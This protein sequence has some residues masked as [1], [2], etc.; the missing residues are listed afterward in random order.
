VYSSLQKTL[1]KVRRKGVPATL[2]LATRAALRIFWARDQVLVF[3][4]RLSIADGQAPVWN[5]GDL[6]IRR[7]HLGDIGDLVADSFDDWNEETFQSIR[8]Q[9]R[10]GDLLYVLESRDHQIV[11]T[12][13]VRTRDE[14]TARE[15]GD[16]LRVKL[17]AEAD[18]IY[19]CWTH[20]DY[21]GQGIHAKTLKHLAAIAHSGARDAWTYRVAENPASKHEIEAGGFRFELKL[22]R[23]QLLHLLVR[24]KIEPESP[25]C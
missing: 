16:S 11:H 17:P 3:S 9:F 7:G 24:G 25:A 13:W 15:V 4:S 6:S 2:Y 12:A 23:T 10:Q 19:D 20:R 21:R 14:I 1:Q 22:T 8:Q 5:S 18:I